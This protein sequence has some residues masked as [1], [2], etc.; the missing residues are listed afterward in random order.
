MALLAVLLVALGLR[1]KTAFLQARGE[2]YLP[3]IVF[4][5]A[6]SGV[7][8]IVALKL[9]IVVVWVGAGFSKFGRHFSMVVP[10]MV[11]NTPWLPLR[12]I[13]RV[14]YKNFPDDL[15]PSHRASLLAHVGG[16]FIEI[17]T[18][19]VLLFSVNRPVT[20]L[21]AAIMICFHLFITST[22]PLAVPLEW[23][24]LF[25]FGAAFLFLGHPNARRVRAR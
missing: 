8:M 15:G 22:F 5:A 19:L 7:N 9:L 16:T 3:A 6:Y 11:S 14:H 12:S 2:Q 25:A 21:A 4:F 1:D 23:N 24:I 20:Y 18:P 17:V 10:P 13:K